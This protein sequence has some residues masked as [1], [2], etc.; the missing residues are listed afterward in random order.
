M[1]FSCS[2]D[3][4]LNGS[5]DRRSAFKS[6]DLT[7][8]AYACFDAICNQCESSWRRVAQASIDHRYI[9]TFTCQ[10]FLIDIQ[11]AWAFDRARARLVDSKIVARCTV[12][13]HEAPIIMTHICSDFRALFL[14]VTHIFSINDL[15][16]FYVEFGDKLKSSTNLSSDG[17]NFNSM[18]IRNSWYLIAK[19]VRWSLVEQKQFGKWEEN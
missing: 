12:T 3:C 9:I 2:T 8:Y 17:Y 6:A 16:C 7:I 11:W 1:T 13:M 15:I 19:F 10:F 18:H 5:N 4:L 14:S